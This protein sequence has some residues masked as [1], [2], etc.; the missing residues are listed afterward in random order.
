MEATITVTQRK[1]T[2]RN[3][4]PYSREWIVA[5]KQGDMVRIKCFEQDESGARAFGDAA[6]ALAKSNG[7]EITCHA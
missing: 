3:L 1:C 2:P 7:M 6:V 5:I 4:Y